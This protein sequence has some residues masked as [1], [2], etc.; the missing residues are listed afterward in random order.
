MICQTK[1]SVNVSLCLILLLSA[2][3][4][5][6]YSFHIFLTDEVFNLIAI[7]ELASGN[8]INDYFFRHPPLYL[9]LS[10]AASFLIGPY[11]QVPSFISIIFSVLS[12]IPL[13]LITRHL[14][15]SRVGLWAS[16]FLAVM[17][18]NIYYSTWIKQDAMLLFFFMWGIY[19]YLKGRY[20]LTGAFTGA[21]LLVKEFAVF[22]FPISMLIT[23]FARE[24][25]RVEDWHGWL[26][27]FLVSVLLS[28]WWYLSYGGSSYKATGEALIG[29][30]IK[31]VMWH[32][33]WWFYVGNIPAD[34]S[35][36]VFILFLC[37][38]VF[39]V[40]E[41]YQY[42]FDKCFVLFAWPLAFYLPL[43][44][45][46][47]KAPWY[48]YLATPPAAI[49]AAFG[50]VRLL[51]LLRSRFLG[52][53]ACAAISVFFIYSLYNFNDIRYFE[54]VTGIPRPRIA[55]EAQGGS[56][57]DLR[58]RKEFWEGRAKGTGRIGFLEFHPALQYLM[59]ISRNETVLL[60]VGDFMALDR[61]GLL[62]LTREYNMGGLLI[63]TDSLTYTERNL[64]DMRYLWGKPVVYGKFLLFLT[65][66]GEGKVD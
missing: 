40:K 6:Y 5:F 4:R 52:I 41:A 14:T 37:G 27:M 53:L 55:M 62:K 25:K 33:P 19:L 58:A 11:P 13:Y 18:I 1:L 48:I 54:D 15:D 22:F 45:I 64:D 24:G 32:S 63:N 12:I 26:K 61:E 16:F 20:L 31:E 8:G 9:L 66:H 28:G 34:L 59:G 17:P 56:W 51:E 46:P 38:A 42:G 36:P 57:E 47:V 10:S 65:K 49:F 3:I 29:S 44:L 35:Y 7:S 30:N 21:A 43:S 23:A 50:M 2:V 60:K 39:C